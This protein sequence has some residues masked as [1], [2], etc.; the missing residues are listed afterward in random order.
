M[1]TQNK[2]T[3][4]VG[5]AGSL[6][7]D[8]RSAFLSIYKDGWTGGIQLSIEDASGSGFR[9]AGPK[10]NGSGKPLLRTKLT[11]RD[12]DEIRRYLDR[13]FPLPN[14]KLTGAQRPA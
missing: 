3:T 10:F 4:T 11:Q 8:P 14:P 12:A 6:A 7:L 1:N 9:L 5:P 2:L 13:A